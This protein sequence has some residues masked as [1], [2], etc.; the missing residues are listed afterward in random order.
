MKFSLPEPVVTPLVRAG[1]LWVKPEGGQLTGS[2]K[3]RMVRA[4]LRAAFLDGA[5]SR[6][7]EARHPGW[8]RVYARVLA[9]GEIATGDRIERVGPAEA[10]Q[11]HAA[12]ARGE[13][14]A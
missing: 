11:V 9:P 8:S 10:A 1:G 12:A 3:F 4:K 14:S 13:A 2:V 7:S 6:V 5:H